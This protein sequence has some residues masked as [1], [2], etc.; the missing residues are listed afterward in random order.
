[1]VFGVAPQPGD[2]RRVKEAMAGVRKGMA[3]GVAL[4]LMSGGVLC[5]QAVAVTVE[6]HK[7]SRTVEEGL[8]EV[9]DPLGESNELQIRIV[10]EPG[11][12]LEFEVHDFV[13]PVTAGPGC[14]KADAMTATCLVHKPGEGWRTGLHLDL[15]GGARNFLDASQL[16]LHPDLPI[17]A[18]GGP[19]EDVF[20]GGGGDD[21][22]DP[23]AGSNAM[24]GNPGN[25]EILAPATADAGDFYDG[26]GGDG[27]RVSY[28]RRVQPVH[29]SEGGVKAATGGDQLI[30]IEILRGGEGDDVLTDGSSP[31][32]YSK[33]E[34]SKLEGGAGDDVLEGAVAG[35]SLLGGPGDDVL[36]GGG[37]FQVPVGLRGSPSPAVNHLLGEEGDDVAYGSDAMDVIELGAGNDTGFGA[38]GSDYLNGGAGEDLLAGGADNDMAV[39]DGGFDRLFGGKGEDRLFAA[40]LVAAGSSHPLTSGNFDGRDWVGCGA[41]RDRAFVNPWDHVQ[42]CERVRK[43]P[44]PKKRAR[45]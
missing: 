9:S 8:L 21:V 37:G 17:V 28:A 5:S 18:I 10:G 40:R 26:G 33:P 12:D 4:A 34:F 20:V 22:L 32:A 38:A 24:Y 35:G 31:S 29:L 19:G 13:A 7:Q 30:G 3:L 43:Q 42:R 41:D 14:E 23:G 44:R 6:T 15:G 2:R 45:R 16:L 1:M 36:S 25:D 11:D 39:G 27:D